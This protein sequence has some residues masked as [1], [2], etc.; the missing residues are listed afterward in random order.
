MDAHPRRWRRPLVAALF[1]LPLLAAGAPVRGADDREGAT[2]VDAWVLWREGGD[3]RS[4]RGERE[5]WREAERAARR[6]RGE[7]FWFRRGDDRYLVTD[8]GALRAVAEL[9]APQQEL[10]RRQRELGKR[11]RELGR[12]QG[13]LGRR[14]GRLGRIQAELGRQQ[15]TL[16]AARAGRDADPRGGAG[17]AAEIRRRQQEAGE[18]QSELGAQQAELGRRQRDLGGQQSE[19]GREQRRVS[20][21]VAVSLDRI[22]RELIASGRAERVTP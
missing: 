17:E 14:Q 20:Q 16:A 7:A 9:F 5:D 8:A 15:A 11:Q 1:A 4:G 19:L 12:L 3:H 18:L 21:E 6:A 10:G 22:T 13:E 2:G